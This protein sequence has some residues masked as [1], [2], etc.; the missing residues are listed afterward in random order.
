MAWYKRYRVPFQ[1]L[2]GTQYIVYIYEQ[3]RGALVT[4]TG[5]DEPFVTFEEASDS[6]FTPVRGQTG[7]LRV[8]DYD[9][10]LME[11]LIP[12][13]N[14][15]K[16]VI[17]YTGTWNDNFTILTDGEIKWQGFLRAEVLT[18][19]W[20][21]ME[22]IEIP[23][24]SILATLENVQVPTAQM[25]DNINTAKII[26]NSIEALCGEHSPYNRLDV[27]CDITPEEHWLYLHVNCATFFHT[28]EVANENDRA[29]EYV[30]KS[31]GEI[32][33][34]VFEFL[35]MTLREDGTNL[36]AAQYD[37]NGFKTLHIHMDWSTVVSIATWNASGGG[38][39]D[40]GSVP[41]LPLLDNVNFCTTN[42][43]V[44][45][46]QGGKSA[47]VNFSLGGLALDITLPFTTE[48]ADDP[49]SKELRSGTLYVQP[50]GPRNLVETFSYY[51]YKR[52]VLQGE[53]TYEDMLAGSVISGYEPIPYYDPSWS[54]YTGAFPCRWF[55]K[56]GTEKIVL[57]NGLY[58]NTQYRS[59]SSIPGV[60]TQNLLYQIDFP[61]ITTMN[62]GWIRLDF[63]WDNI[64]WSTTLGKYLFTD[65]QSYFGHDVM[66]EIHMCM[67][68][69]DKWWDGSQW[70]TGGSAP[71]TNFWFRMK[72]SDIPTNKT[73][74]MN[75]DVDDGWFIPVTETLTGT[76][77]FY[78]LNFVPV[79][80]N[81]NYEYCYSHILHDLSIT[82][83]LPISIVASERGSNVYRK[84]ILM[85]GFN[86]E[87]TI[88]LSVGTYNNNQPHPCFITLNG[89]TL[90]ETMD[91]ATEPS[92]SLTERPE[93]H[94]L[95]RMVSYYD[96][97]RRTFTA[98]HRGALDL[99]L[100]LY[101]YGSRKFFAVG[102]EKNWRD[103]EEKVTFIEVT[104]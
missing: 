99:M 87:K 71:G 95:N 9:G 22:M 94:L 4:L 29:V 8:I 7:Y 64:I 12:S 14:T 30:G 52:N 77:S 13:N 25:G 46:I 2:E 31:Y 70:V 10:T 6:I 69:G 56:T 41:E 83:I 102:A 68:V 104:S 44:T 53:S 80:E 21:N 72:N 28:Q 78:I 89:T 97:I 103:D 26:T 54:L 66:S 23:I 1:S 49:L 101:T 48:S 42:N 3:T 33:R 63:K 37:K 17:L 74:D 5:A 32:L 84:N 55:Y 58:I 45:Y 81:S 82:H 43:S 47:V 79:T 35:G 65:A 19:P 57:K 16:M 76:V 38:I 60:I 51:E 98:I 36:I 88:N 40:D 59:S 90:I 67:R 20:R 91:Y 86:E 75:I 61:I 85:S 15:Q 50:Q 18:Q 100:S 39:V 62:E 27:I 93:M 92:G 34:H 96:T 24:Q 11:S 73:S